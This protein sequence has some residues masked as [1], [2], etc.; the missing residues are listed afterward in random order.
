MAKVAL[1]TADGDEVLR[2]AG[3]FVRGTG[4][5]RED[6][7]GDIG[8]GDGVLAGE[9]G[10]AFEADDGRPWGAGGAGEAQIPGVAGPAR[11]HGED[12]SA[13]TGGKAGDDVGLSGRQVGLVV[14]LDVSDGAGEVRAAP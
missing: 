11:A 5:C 4:E 10:G 2:C 12:R 8:E 14:G 9:V 3:V 6:V 13:L 7:G 1:E